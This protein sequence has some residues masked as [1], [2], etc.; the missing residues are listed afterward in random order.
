MQILLPGQS[1]SD[2]LPHSKSLRGARLS[3]LYL[4]LLLLSALL[5][6]PTSHASS[7]GVS[8]DSTSINAH[9]ATDFA[10]HALSD[11]HKLNILANPLA[12]YASLTPA[13][14]DCQPQDDS[15]PRHNQAPNKHHSRFEPLISQRLFSSAGHDSLQH[16]PVYAL[17]FEFVTA[18]APSLSIG[19][20]VDFASS[21]IWSLQ[22]SQSRTRLAG[23]KDTN[24][25]YRL[26]QIDRIS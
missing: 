8:T 23:W 15:E 21:R 6:A 19:Y 14:A 5:F 7:L 18:P 12:Q 24:L 16:R 2:T 20:R 11:A 25:L 3:A 4:L 13:W 22:H 17:A 10:D 9:I 1:L 26:S